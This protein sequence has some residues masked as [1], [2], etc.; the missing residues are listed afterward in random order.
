MHDDS[1]QNPYH[2]EPHAMCIRMSVCFFLIGA[3]LISAV[4]PPHSA[5]AAQVAAAVLAQPQPAPSVEYF[6]VS[7]Y[8]GGNVYFVRQGKKYPYHGMLE[9]EFL[10]PG[11]STSSRA[12]A[13]AVELQFAL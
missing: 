8:D 3:G 6:S 4:I 10:Q 7:D 1:S 12:A 9:I 11:G 13:T 5:S 2:T